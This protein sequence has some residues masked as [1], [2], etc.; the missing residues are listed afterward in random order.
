VKLLRQIDKFHELS[1]YIELMNQLQELRRKFLVREVDSSD[2]VG[3][4]GSR[5]RQNAG[6]VWDVLCKIRLEEILEHELDLKS[7]SLDLD[8]THPTLI[9]L[10]GRLESADAIRRNRNSRDSRRTS[11]RLDDKFR[12]KFDQCVL[13]NISISQ[14]FRLK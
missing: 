1:S 8:I 7:L 9:R 14:S 10:L 6:L 2:F 12:D 5:I 11:I 3:R 4:G 13:D